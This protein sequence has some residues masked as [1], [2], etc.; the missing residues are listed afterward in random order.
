[1]S[2]PSDWI[3]KIFTKLTLVYGRAFLDRWVGLD[4]DTVKDD[5]A[6]ELDGFEKNPRAIA[7]ALRNLPAEKPPTVLEFRKLAYLTP[8]ADAPQIAHQ[9]ADLARVAAEV[10]KL[11]PLREAPKSGLRDWAHRLKAK[12]GADPKSVTQTI[13]KFYKEALNEAV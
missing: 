5:W 3:E 10:A 8:K 4:M 13:R 9:P 6:H 1:M 2:L 12:D 7:W 11:A